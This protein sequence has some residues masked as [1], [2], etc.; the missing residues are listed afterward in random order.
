MQPYYF[1]YL[2]YYQ[3]IRSVDKLIILDDVN[4]IKQG[5]INRNK[6]NTVDG[7]YVFTIPIQK[8]KAN[9]NIRDT[10]IANNYSF[11]VNKYIKTIR[12]HF[13]KSKDLE[14]IVRL[15]QQSIDIES[16]SI[17]DIATNSICG[18]LDYFN[19]QV[20]IEISSI[21]YPSTLI[22]SSR[23]IDICKKSQATKYINLPGGQQLYMKSDF[24]KENIG[25]CFIDYDETSKK[26]GRHSH[27]SILNSILNLGKDQT[28]ELISQY[29][30]S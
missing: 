22:G 17:S 18:I 19:F 1:P 21:N 23:V 20:D 13:S 16:R 9:T 8:Q 27:Y 3:L 30:L 26:M 11:F 6:I 28:R 4:Y 15:F 10:Y 25:L 5:W 12:Q 24:S 14:D 7:D 29:N 2:G